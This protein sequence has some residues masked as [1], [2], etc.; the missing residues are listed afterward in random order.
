[1]ANTAMLMQ[2]YNVNRENNKYLKIIASKPESQIGVSEIGE[3]FAK[4]KRGGH[5]TNYTFYQGPERI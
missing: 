3:L 1:M 4:I 2:I 5:S